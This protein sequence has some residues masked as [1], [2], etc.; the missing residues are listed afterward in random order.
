TGCPGGV[1]SPGCWFCLS[2]PPVRTLYRPMTVDTINERAAAEFFT[3]GQQAE[4]E[5]NL[6][7][8]VENYQHALNEDPDHEDSCFRLAVLYDR[9]GQDSQAIELYERLCAGNPVPMTALLNLAVLYE[10]NNMYEDARR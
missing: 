5:G 4:T 8:A 10:D 1:F 7:S 9:Q 2:S 3:R 6:E